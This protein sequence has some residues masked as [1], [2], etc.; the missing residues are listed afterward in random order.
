MQFSSLY[1]NM[2]CLKKKIPTHQAAGM[3]SAGMGGMDYQCPPTN[4][5]DPDLTK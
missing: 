2:H 1:K 3:G 4:I 5:H